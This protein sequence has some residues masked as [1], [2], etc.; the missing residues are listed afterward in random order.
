MN[1]VNH[2]EETL[3]DLEESVDMDSL[4][5]G[6]TI[7]T[8]INKNLKTASTQANVNNKLTKA[9]DNGSTLDE[10]WIALA[11]KSFK[12]EL[13]A[14]V[15]VIKK[16]VIKELKLSE[17]VVMTTLTLRHHLAQ[18]AGH[19]FNYP[20]LFEEDIEGIDKDDLLLKLQWFNKLAI[21]D[22]SITYTLMSTGYKLAILD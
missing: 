11:N 13:E 12:A 20:E 21:V 18:L 17:D 14:K 7:V 19:R 22:Y 1:P 9:Q 4:E 3:K 2:Q 15:D 10:Q 16:A 5:L 6:H 8:G